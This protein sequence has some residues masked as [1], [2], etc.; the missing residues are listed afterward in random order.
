MG[1]CDGEWWATG[2]TPPDG[3]DADH[4]K[5]QDNDDS[6]DGGWRMLLVLTLGLLVLVVLAGTTVLF[7]VL[8]IHSRHRHH[9]H[10]QQQH[11]GERHHASLNTVE[12]DDGV[13]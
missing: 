7:A 13:F 11:L 8:W 10:H 6:R 3:E 5:H 9:H 2:S 1:P 4:T 12:L